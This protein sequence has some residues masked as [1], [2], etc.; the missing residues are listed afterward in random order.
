MDYY[1]IS[2]KLDITTA[3]L[4]QLSFENLAKSA[5]AIA[6]VSHLKPFL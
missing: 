1:A 3:K 5:S 6:K 4:S 2:K